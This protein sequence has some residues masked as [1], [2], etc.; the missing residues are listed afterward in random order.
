MYLLNESGLLFGCTVGL[1]DL[2]TGISILAMGEASSDIVF[3]IM[4]CKEMYHRDA[5]GDANARHAHTYSAAACHAP[6]LLQAARR[7]HQ[8][9]RI[10]PTPCRHVAPRHHCQPDC[11]QQGPQRG[12][13]HRKHHWVKQVRA[14]R[15][16]QACVR[17]STRACALSF[18]V[19]ISQQASHNASDHTEVVLP[20]LPALCPPNP[21]A[22]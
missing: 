19:V 11:C 20:H 2:M 12:C 21:N 13:R 18:L 3:M 9:T 5:S 14:C 7:T 8:R 17:A 4:V 15:G 6:P 16:A 10:L 22:T 1:S